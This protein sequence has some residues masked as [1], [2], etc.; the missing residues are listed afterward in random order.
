MIAIHLSAL[1]NVVTTTLNCHHNHSLLTAISSASSIIKIKDTTTPLAP[2]GSIDVMASETE[3]Q[4]ELQDRVN[5]V[6][7]HRGT[8]EFSLSL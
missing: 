3:S 4:S 7:V 5:Q 8:I 1:I 2:P 6:V